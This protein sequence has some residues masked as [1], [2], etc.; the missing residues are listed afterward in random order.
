M[1]NVFPCHRFDLHNTL[2][3]YWKVTDDLFVDGDLVLHG[4]CVVILAALH[5][6]I[7]ACLHDSH[8]GAEATKCHA[9]QAASWPV[10]NTDITNTSHARQCSIANSRTL[11]CATTLFGP[12]SQRQPTTSPHPGKLV[13]TNQLSGWPAAVPCGTNTTS[14]ATIRWFQHLHD[15]GVWPCPRM[16]SNPSS[17]G[18]SQQA[19]WSIMA[20][21][22]TYQCPSKMVTL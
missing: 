9:G 4:A 5:S 6:C 19:S 12:S 10:I 2:H 8:R 7:L 14:S 13:V 18:G 11:C 20:L 3:P 21:V 15:F 17:L 1:R 16:N 22:T